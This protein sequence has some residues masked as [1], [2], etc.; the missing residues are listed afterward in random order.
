MSEA[1][2]VAP[3]PATI[4][5][6][7]TEA[8]VFIRISGRANFTSSV[9]LKTLVS[10]LQQRGHSRF[11]LDLA[12]CLIMDSTFLG[13]L[14]GIALRLSKAQSGGPPIVLNNPNPRITDLLEN[15]GVWN[16]FCVSN[17]ENISGPT[18]SPAMTAAEKPSKEE[19]SRTCLEAHRTLMAVNPA[20]VPKFKEVTQFLAENLDHPKPASGE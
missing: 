1:S 7:L 9:H 18:Y 10:E 16:L 11:V 14:A 19:I 13:V 2:P 8:V 12:G 4:L 17:A 3:P 5:V 15:L 20:N 6:A